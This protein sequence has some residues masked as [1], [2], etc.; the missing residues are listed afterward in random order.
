[1]IAEALGS[2]AAAVK[3]LGGEHIRTLVQL[4]L[5]RHERCECV[6]LP[7]RLCRGHF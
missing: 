5:D 4:L 6:A 7:L 3:G 1:V 2:H